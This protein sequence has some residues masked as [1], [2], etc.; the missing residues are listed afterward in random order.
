MR[1]QP[2]DPLSCAVLTFDVDLENLLASEAN[3][4]GTKSWLST[5]DRVLIRESGSEFL[6]RFWQMR[7]CCCGCCFFFYIAIV[8]VKRAV[9]ADSRKDTCSR[10]VFRHDV[11]LT[12][13]CLFPLWNV[14][15]LTFI[16][17]FLLWL[18]FFD[19]WMWTRNERHET[20]QK[21]RL[22]QVNFF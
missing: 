21:I 6:E 1:R 9:V 22:D 20:K 18:C 10:E 15:I 14:E 8:G 3:V 5:H 17:Y 7:V 11:R 16:L 12:L 13:P 2:R 4:V 19:G